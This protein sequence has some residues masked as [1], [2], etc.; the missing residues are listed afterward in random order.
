MIIIV[1]GVSGCG[2]TTIG[3]Q[4]SQSMKVPFYD[5]DDF[6]PLVNVQKMANGEPLNDDDRRP[7]L[8]SLADH[9]VQWKSTG[10]AVLACSALKESYRKILGSGMTEIQWVY[11]PGTYDQIKTR[12]ENREDHYMKADLLRSQ[13]EALEEP[14]YGIRVDIS[15]SPKEIVHSILARWNDAR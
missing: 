9:I 13:F 8:Q 10:G 14:D 6:H 5:A 11:L 15:L 12:M 4:L 2:K 1:M 7:W 3:K